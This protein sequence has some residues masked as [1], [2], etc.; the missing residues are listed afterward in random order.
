MIDGL[1]PYPQYKE[2]GLPWLGKVPEHWDMERAKRLFRKMDRPVRTSDDVVTCF[3]DGTVTLRRNRR[4]RGF[5]ESLKEIGYQGI[6]RGDLVIHAMDAFA[7]A[8]GVSDSDG[9]GTPVYSICEPNAGSNSHFYA[10]ILREMARS[11]WIQALAKGIR[12]R[13]TDF[14]FDDFASQKVP[15]PPLPEQTAIIRF[16]DHVDRC[17]RQYVRAKRLLIDRYN[18]L[19][20]S[21]VITGDGTGNPQSG[22]WRMS[23]P[24]E[25]RIEKAKRLF[26][27]VKVTDCPNKDLLAVTQDRGILPKKMCEQHFVSPSKNLEG[28]KLVRPNDFVISLRSF[29][30]GIEHS[31][32]E[33]IVSPAY[34]VFRLRS[35]FQ[36]PEYQYFYKYLFKSPQFIALLATLISGIRDGKNIPYSDFAE[37]QLPVTPRS[38]ISYLVSLCKEVEKYQNAVLHEINFLLEYQKRLVADVVTGKLDVREAAEAL[39]EEDDEPES[40]VE[41]IAINESDE[42]DIEENSENEEEADSE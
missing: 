22:F 24:N 11:Q 18:E 4:V 28:L 13:S 25:W 9:K 33:G 39:P 19:I 41:E 2:T 26:D 5:T 12:E 37:L 30:G 42:G 23:L 20:F 7:G 1:K 34:I 17:V 32:Y 31:D 21:L 14:R 35:E 10:Y 40:L 3:R 6:R 16:L 38:K 8:I 15:I 36:Y 27:E 29:Q